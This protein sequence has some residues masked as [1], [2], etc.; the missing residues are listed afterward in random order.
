M[1]SIKSFE[2][3][4]KIKLM[5]FQLRPIYPMP[6]GPP[7]ERFPKTILQFWLLTESEI[8]SMARYYSQ[9]QPDEYTLTYPR[10]LNWDEQLFERMDQNERLFM[11]RRELGLF[12]GLFKE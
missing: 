4:S 11:K 7:H 3:Q 1:K 10:P 9:S 2:F 8:D 6:T 5:K 12:I